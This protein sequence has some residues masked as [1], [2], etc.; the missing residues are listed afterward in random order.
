MTGDEVTALARRALD[1]VLAG[2]R[3]PLAVAHP[4]DFI[5]VPVLRTPGFGVCG[6]IW[7]DGETSDT[8]HSHSWH[9]DS[10]VI[11]GAVTNEVFAVTDDPGGAHELFEV[12]STGRLDVF[13]PAERTVTCT[14]VRREEHPAGTS[15]RLPAKSFH[16]SLPGSAGRTLTLLSATT[17]P[18][19]CDQVVRPVCS[20]PVRPVRR[21]ELPHPDALG[22]AGLLRSAL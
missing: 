15:Y 2:D 8:V 5:C 3:P 9:L 11:A 14:A 20:A 4:L 18:D 22:F 10:L 1:A 7:H 21:R 17:L 12:T 16:R 13:T 6:H 19:V